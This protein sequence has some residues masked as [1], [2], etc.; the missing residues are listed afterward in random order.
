MDKNMKEGFKNWLKKQKKDDG[1]E[2]SPNTINSYCQQ[3]NTAP[4]KLEG[5]LNDYKISVFEYSNLSE[6][7]KAENAILNAPNFED[8]NR[9]A[10]NQAFK[11]GLKK[12][13]EFLEQLQKNVHGENAMTDSSFDNFTDNLS[14]LLK[15][16][17]NLILHGAPGTGKT[18]LA[19]QIAEKMGCTKDEIGFVQFHPS[20][21]YTDFV[22]GLRPVKNENSSQPEFERRDGVFKD[23]CKTALSSFKEIN[24]VDNFKECYEK[25]VKKIEEKNFVEVKTISKNT[26]FHV[27]LNEYENGLATRTYPNDEYKKGEW[28]AG[29]SRFYTE[30]QLYNIYRGLPGVPKG[31]HDNYR[32]AIIQ[33]MK[34]NLGLKDYKA[35]KKEDENKKYVF[36]IDE[37]NRGELS[38]IFGELFYAIDPGY[39]VKITNLA[40]QTPQ[41]IRTQYSNMQD[42]PNDFDILLKIENPSDFGH[43]FVPENVY[44]IGTMNDIDRSVD[45][46]DFA[47]RR[48]FAFKEIL[49]NENLGMFEDL[50]DELKTEA[51][52]R[53]K[54]LNAAIEKIEGLS[55]AYHIGGSYFLKL[56]K[57]DDDI[58]NRFENLW[59]HHLSGLL[60]EYLRG[61]DDADGKFN[62]LKEVYFGTDKTESNDDVPEKQTD[63][64]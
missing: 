21:D 60:K 63:L 55:T 30:E 54:R 22:E 32:K 35:G 58:K 19:K 43:F 11:Y 56:N 24:S 42:E 39:R 17:H 45:S 14:E 44:I 49:A 47:F 64:N 6:Y 28:I 5:I 38:K 41:T 15:Y 33:Y 20:Y 13:K 29:H 37:I 57:F 51:I 34:D 27:E 61:F 1:T 59:N 2:Y 26:S 3:L 53:M 12:Y 10:G 62:L 25:L 23:F 40:E 18:Y 4:S 46:M 31:G 7:L 8:V 52:A 36:I 50:D 9:K 48:R 16:T